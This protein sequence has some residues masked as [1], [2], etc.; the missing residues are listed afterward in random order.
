MKKYLYENRWV[1]QF[2]GHVF[3]YAGM[4]FLM[5]LILKIPDTMIGGIGSFA[6]VCLMIVFGGDETVIRLAKEFVAKKSPSD[7]GAPDEDE[8]KN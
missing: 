6:L 1:A 5:G 3:A 4:A 7:V 2:I 8:A